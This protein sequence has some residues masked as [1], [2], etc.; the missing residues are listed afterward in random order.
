MKW[1][2]RFLSTG[3]LLG[4][5]A[6]KEV[7]TLPEIDVSSA[8][9]GVV[10]LPPETPEVL[11]QYFV[12]Y[13]NVIAPNGKPIHILAADRWTDDQIRHGRDVLEFL[14]TDYPG[15]EY[16]DDKTAIANAMSD[17]KATM[18]FFNTP[19]ELEAAFEGRLAGA[20]DLSMQDLRAN[21]SPAV[22]DADYMAHVT[23]DASYEEIWHLIHDYGIKPTLPAMIAEMRT[24]NDAAEASGWKGWPDDEPEE[25]PNEYV[26]VLIDNYYDLW[27]V[28]PTLYESRPIEPGDIPEGHSHF[29]RYF[30]NT[31]EAM[32]DK[33]P[34]GF[35]LIEKFLPPHLTYTPQLPGDFTGTFSMSL[36]PEADYTYKTQHLRGA[37]LIGSNDAELIGNGHD[38]TLTGNAGA[39]VL[40]GGGGN[41]VL[42]GGEGED[43][44]IFRGPASDYQ[45]EAEGET[46]TVTDSDEE[47]DG[48]DCLRGVEYLKFSDGEVPVAAP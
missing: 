14:L 25:H 26:G 12:K 35:A 5:C 36:D 34:A 29:G 46:V 40:T 33:D 48:S 9:G 10:A 38:N 44:A 8:P 24:A 42:D 4:A 15:S 7:V 19:E 2:A 22:G 20:T 37:T 31:R 18:V 13:T 23:R 21:E 1:V 27:A 32:R 6:P 47:R 16:G 41:D 39:N 17:R 45:I 43:T 30:A 3:L 28:H 11:K